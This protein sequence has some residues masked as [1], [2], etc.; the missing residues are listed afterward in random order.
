MLGLLLMACGTSETEPAPA[1]PQ[2]GQ[3][4]SPSWQASRRALLDALQLPVSSSER[5]RATLGPSEPLDG[6]AM[7]PLTWDPPDI[8]GDVV[9]GAVYR[10]D[11]VPE[12]ALPLLINVHG[13]WGGGIEADE[14]NRRAILFAQQGWL[15]LSVANRGV[16]HGIDTPAWRR[17]HGRP[18]GFALARIRRGGGA[19]LTWDIT[20]ART[21]LDLALTGQ[22]GASVDR[23]RIATIGFSG[24]AERAAVLAA[25]DPRIAAV[26]LGAYEYAFS[27]GHGAAGCSCGAVRGANEPLTDHPLQ[28]TDLPSNAS[29]D[30]VPIQGWRWLALAG[31]R[32]G[33]SVTP[34]PVL[35]WDNFF[36]DA[37]DVELAALPKVTRR[38]VTGQ[39]GVS[40]E[41]AAGSWSWLDETLGRAPGVSPE[42]AAQKADAGYS[43]MHRGWRPPLPETLPAPGQ[44]E[45]GPP[46]WRADPGVRPEA[47]LRLLGLGEEPSPAVRLGIR[48]ETGVDVL[49]AIAAQERL[50][51]DGGVGGLTARGR[52]GWLVVTGGTPGPVPA[53]F[54]DKVDLPWVDGD[55]QLAGL[56][57]LGALRELA[58]DAVFARVDLRVGRTAEADVSAS[59]WGAELGVP[60]MGV[61]VQDVL[62]A[63]K[64][65]RS[66]PEVDPAKVGLVGIGPG[67]VQV[68]HA[69]GLI[70]EGGPGGLAGAPVTQ[71]FE[72]ASTGP[73]FYPWPSWTVAP[74]RGGASL[75]P[76]PA[77]V[78]LGDRL[79]WLDPR[80]GD[81]QSW[82]EELPAGALAKDL[83]G[84]LKETR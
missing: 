65:L 46:P 56:G 77:A 42:E 50:A 57:G 16:E 39:H 49:P 31:C 58:P 36:D 84:L 82:V 21:G 76:W 43:V 53:D 25:V 72:G 81:G 17:S 38:D 66:H 61:A 2:T 71:G 18:A 78:A 12:G 9:F 11:P 13:H 5:P 19:A 32:P 45:Q 22:L 55:A 74:V 73:V 67:G 54:T 64:R 48:E 83:A 6:W 62:D 69:A 52:A 28:G 34:R 26:V 63:H 27:S 59:G 37:V 40:P 70:G 29:G 35:L 20:A 14:V 33:V 8:D 10:P 75:D 80:G 23:E 51:L 1:A 60:P 41:V 24:G 44:K 3:C 79:R 47:L 15:V 30:T 68:L 7:Q 4:N